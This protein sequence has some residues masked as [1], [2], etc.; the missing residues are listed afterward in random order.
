MTG[1]CTLPDEIVLHI[2]GLVLPAD[3]E[4]FAQISKK[5]QRVARPI[6]H[7]HRERIRTHSLFQNRSRPAATATLLQNVL[8]DVRIGH[9]VRQMTL[10]NR[11]YEMSLTPQQFKLFEQAGAQYEWLVSL[12]DAVLLDG[13]GDP[14]NQGWV[15]EVCLTVL[16][17]LLPNL[18]SINI[19]VGFG[20]TGFYAC[21]VI[22]KA[23]NPLSAPFSRL[24][25][26][27]FDD[28]KTCLSNTR[29]FGL[30][31]SVR[32]LLVRGTRHIPGET[33]EDRS[34]S[35][36]QHSKV[37]HLSLT[38][39]EDS[40]ERLN[41][42]LRVFSLLQSFEYTY[43]EPKSDMW[44]VPPFEPYEPFRICSGLLPAKLTLKKLVILG[45]NCAIPPPLGRRNVAT[46]PFLGS[47]QEFLALEEIHVQW[48][49]LPSTSYDSL[50]L[51]LPSILPVTLRR[52]TLEGLPPQKRKKNL[53]DNLNE[54]LGAASC[55]KT[56]ATLPN[57]E[58]LVFANCPY[59]W[60]SDSFSIQEKLERVS[61]AGIKVTFTPTERPPHE[62][63]GETV[64]FGKIWTH[65]RGERSM[66]YRTLRW[67][68]THSSIK[69]S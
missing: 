20:Y 32:C 6:L 68:K 52:L 49:S 2:L 58:G 57:W 12:E 46:P 54:M 10:R 33:Y 11:P 16:L 26:V 45:P 15:E 50:I 41:D 47:L 1:L 62:G 23:P 14:H 29:P 64:G 5:I 21:Q 24:R 61:A 7:E 3:L 65:V 44:S 19:D 53:S 18:S 25:T 36:G 28:S 38:E 30:M 4:N 27:I 34:L 43:R 37:T 35:L 51:G 17:P 63:E 9:Y 48:S 40:C 39:C 42:Y 60:R 22:G 69:R 56:N 13:R 31:P 8:N 59:H 55:A 67:L 66:G